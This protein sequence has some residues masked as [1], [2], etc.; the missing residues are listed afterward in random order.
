[1]QIF[2]ISLS[3]AADRRKFQQDQLSKLGLEYTIINATSV[4]DIDKEIYKKHFF[5]WQRPLSKTEIACYY[6]H[7]SAWDRII[8]SNLPALILEDDALLSKCVPSIL[9]RLDNLKAVD[10]VN[11]E[12][13]SR[14]K[15][16]ARNGLAIA[17]DSVIF[18]LYQDR[19]GAAGYT[20]WPSGAKKLI[21]CERTHGIALTDAHITSCYSLQSYQVEPSPIIQLDQC[22]CYDID[23]PNSIHLSVSSVSSHHNSKGG[24]TSRINRIYNQLNMGLRQLYLI[25]KSKRRYI[26]IRIDDF[27]Y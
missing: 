13:R 16:V 20:L 14:K 1:V 2:V 18:K 6:S 26:E 23:N 3:N 25:T 15:F 10:L 4:D 11:L 21:T 19:T 8:H 5:D 17:C 22:H 24:I 27:Y 9:S 7:R 12:N